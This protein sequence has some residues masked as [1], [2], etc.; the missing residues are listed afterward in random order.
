MKKKILSIMLAMTMVVASCAGCGSSENEV[1]STET[2]AEAV[3]EETEAVE[4]TETVEEDA[5][6]ETEELVDIT[7]EDTQISIG[8]MTGPT[9]MSLVKMMK[10]AEDAG[11]KSAYTFAELATDA[12]A[13]LPALSK[14][15]LDI[16][17]IPSN[18]AATV[19]NNTEG[20]ICILATINTG[21]LNIVERGESVNSIADLK[22]KT[23]YATGQGAVPEYTIR[24]LL[25][26]NG[27]DPDSD[28]TITWCA[29]TTEALS[30][31]SS[32]EA[33][34]AVLPQPF[35]VAAC[36]QVEGLRVAVDLN[37]E[38]TKLDNGCQIITG[39]IAARKEFVD[40]NP[41]AVEKFL[42]EYAESVEYT[43][44]DVEGAAALIEQYGIVAKAPIAQKALPGCHLVCMVGDEMK[45]SVEGFLNILFEQ[46]P[47][48]VG[49]AMPG[50]DFYYGITK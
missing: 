22:G 26:E 36:A 48:A 21:V 31:I 8:A 28:L 9:A 44:D 30:Y 23:V 41:E 42:A 10:D 24:Y 25:S 37:D 12:S 14:G 39:V 35:V 47:K 27:V 45:T 6:E 3:E 5:A 49:G 4:E 38:W 11:D 15:E 20:S 32:D 1:T 40:N 16:A 17:A 43:N 13:L 33:A 46:N 34:I 50:D 2:E 18:A 29:D 19:Y 7:D